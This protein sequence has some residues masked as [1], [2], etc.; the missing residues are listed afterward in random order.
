[1]E[2]FK[3]SRRSLE[4]LRGIHP[5]L[6]KVTDLAL[7]LSEVDFI[8]TDGL[9]TEEEQRE[10]VRKGASRTMRSRHLTGHAID[11]VAIVNNKVRYDAVH[12]KRI[13]HAFKMAAKQLGIPI[14]WGGDWKSFVDTPH[15]ELDRKV[16]K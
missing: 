3:W 7:K 9:R 16:Y 2:N 1:M 4:Q 10:L 5:D 12:M 14:E 13:A 15:I 11:F 6:R 8:I